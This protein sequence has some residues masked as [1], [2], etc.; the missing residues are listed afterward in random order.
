M[1]ALRRDHPAL[2][3]GSFRSVAT[4]DAQDVW[5]FAREHGDQRVLVLLNGSEQTQPI[6]IDAREVQGWN[7]NT[8]FV[9]G[10]TQ[11][12]APSDATR[13][14]LVDGVPVIIPALGARVLVG[15][16]R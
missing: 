9:S 4:L 6:T 5:I 8:A 1:I 14:P 16:R 7:W 15:T 12:S 2:Q 11:V 3:V 13:A 10:N